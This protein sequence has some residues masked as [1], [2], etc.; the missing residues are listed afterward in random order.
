[1]HKTLTVVIVVVLIL[2]V[3]IYLR[4][5]H[6]RD[7]IIVSDPEYVPVW[8]D[9]GY[10]RYWPWTWW[11]PYYGHSD[12]GSY[13]RNHHIRNRGFDGGHAGQARF[14]P[15]HGISPHRGG[16]HFGGRGGHSGGR[17]H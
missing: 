16:G 15:A 7:T 12:G 3:M 10:G 13:V 17:H 6:V 14:G 5:R 11:G 4:H 9:F 1:M 8:Y 2:M